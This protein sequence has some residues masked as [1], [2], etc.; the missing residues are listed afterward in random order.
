MFHHISKNAEKRVKN[1]T[2]SGFPLTHFTIYDETLCLMSDITS[3]IK[4][5]C[6]RKHG[7]VPNLSV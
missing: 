1:P 7:A 2:G 3:Q 4:I 6:L 5:S